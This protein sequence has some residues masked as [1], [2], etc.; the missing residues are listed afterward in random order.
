MKT[1]TFYS[2]PAGGPRP[3]AL[4]QG[5]V[6]AAAVMGVLLFLMGRGGQ[7]VVR[8]SIGSASPRAGLL[9]VQTGEAPAKPSTEVAVRAAR[10]RPSSGRLFAYF[11]ALLALE[12]LDTD[13]DL[14]ISD[15]EMAH[16]P[17]AL[18]P[19]DRNRDGRLSPAECGFEVPAGEADSGFVQRARTWY[20]RIH[21][22]LAALDADGNGVISPVELATATASLRAL[23]WNH[24]EALTSDELLPD[25]V[26]NALAVYMVRWDRDGD[27]GIS[28]H[29]ASAMPRELRE[30][31][32]ATGAGE[33]C[34]TEGALRNEIRRRAMS[35]G[36]AGARQLELAGRGGTHN[37]Y[38]FYR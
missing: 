20:M 19:L 31:L 3:L 27:G 6:A 11:R 29:E 34:V 13:R 12:A 23:D 28:P 37:A 10:S 9:E 14:A 38:D 32:P 16:A 5:A 36:D 24:D 4:V 25:P 1:P 17:A 18:R 7:H 30:V 33:T 15:A 2:A 26:V 22:L 8:L 21:P 35:D